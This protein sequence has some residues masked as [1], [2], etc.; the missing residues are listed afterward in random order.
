MVSRDTETEIGHSARYE[1][2]LAVFFPSNNGCDAEFDCDR[3]VVT[4]I[5]PYTTEEML[6]DKSVHGYQGG[7]EGVMSPDPSTPT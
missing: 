2:R 6:R 1:G 5:D 4:S 3:T 7:G